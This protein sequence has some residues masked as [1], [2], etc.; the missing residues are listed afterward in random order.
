[1][2]VRILLALRSTIRERLAPS[3]RV[4]VLVNCQ[5]YSVCIG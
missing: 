2:W 5:L 4:K 1:M 3:M